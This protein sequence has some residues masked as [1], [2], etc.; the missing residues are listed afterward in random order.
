MKSAERY[1][2]PPRLSKWALASIAAVLAVGLGLLLWAAWGYATTPARSQIVSFRADDDRSLTVRYQ[3]TR[4]DPDQAIRC[5]IEAQD[6]D[7]VV[8]GEVT[9]LIPPGLGTLTRTVTV[10]TRVRAV[11]AVVEQCRP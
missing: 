6:Y 5:K 2:S 10:P 7:R 9:D 3:L 1:G 11:A 8:V 4:R